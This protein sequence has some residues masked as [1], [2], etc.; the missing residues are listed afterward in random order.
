MRLRASSRNS[1]ASCRNAPSSSPAPPSAAGSQS[2]RRLGAAFALTSCV[3]SNPRPPARQSSAPRSR[4]SSPSS[5]GRTPSAPRAG[6]RSPRSRDPRYPLISFAPPLL[7]PPAARTRS[8]RP[9]S[10]APVSPGRSPSRSR[11]C[12]AAPPRRDA[13]VTVGVHPSDL[14]L[15]LLRLPAATSAR[16]LR[17]GCSPDARRGRPVPPAAAQAAWSRLVTATC[18]T[19]S[20]QPRPRSPLVSSSVRRRSPSARELPP[21]RSLV[22]LHAPARDTWSSLSAAA[23]LS[24]ATRRLPATPA[25]TR[26][27]ASR[28]HLRAQPVH[29]CWPNRTS[30]AHPDVLKLSYSR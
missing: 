14:V 15:A 17:P 23:I 16:P 25:P 26:P 22:R 20:T 2:Y 24:R 3:F 13:L 10:V 5:A 7:Q 21:E 30:V 28:R 4:G 1:G 6:A 8:R 18:S 12:A 19:P 11:S 29:V 27:S 9:A